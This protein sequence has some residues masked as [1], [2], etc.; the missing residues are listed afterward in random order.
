MTKR[1]LVLW[2][3]DRSANLG[4]RALAEGTAELVRT[5]WPGA[6]VVTASYGVRGGAP[7]L[8]GHYRSVARDWVSGRR[9]LGRWLRGFDVVIDTRAGDSFSDL[10][11]IQRLLTMSLLAE[12]CHR[13]GVPVVLGPQTVGPFATRRG[14]AIARRTL[15]TAREVLTRDAVSARHSTALGR[16][17][18]LVSTDVVF[19]L[20]IP[21][22]TH[23]HDVLLNISGL[24]WHGGA[25]LDAMK[26]RADMAEVYQGLLERGRNV[27]LLAH[28]LDS[29]TSDNDVSAIREFTAEAAPGEDVVIPESLADVRAHVAGANLV[30]G[31]RMHACLNA[32]SVGTP[33]IAMAYSRKFAPLLGELGWDQVV[34]L[35][36]DTDVV[37]NV[38]RMSEAD[39]ADR[40]REV[41]ARA[42]RVRDETVATLRASL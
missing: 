25:G 34:D 42:A 5:T 21:G 14:R 31:A 16:Q 13:S 20:P 2:S 30:I 23:K 7:V 4:V 24:L 29:A 6:T 26:Y 9:A 8:I 35:Q 36:D 19:M 12:Y 18:G 38:L 27:S 15:G 37:A 11:G 17:P 28:V 41:A 32:L 40:A 10:Y 33:A 22:R 39:S 1:V 3:D